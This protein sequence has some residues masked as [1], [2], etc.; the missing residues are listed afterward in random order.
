MHRRVWV[1]LCWS[2]AASGVAGCGTSNSPDALGDVPDSA[3]DA[4]QVGPPLAPGIAPAWLSQTGYF[5]LGAERRPYTPAFPLWSDGAGKSRSVYLPAPIDNTDPD[6]WSF[7]VGAKFWKEFGLDGKLIETRYIERFG[8][9]PDDFL[10][11][12]YLWPAS[13][14]GSPSDA[15]LV[16]ADQE[17]DDAN[18]TDHDVPTVQQCHQCHDKTAEHILGFG[19]IEL[20]QG[21]AGFA[22]SALAQA[23]LLTSP[24]PAALCA[25]PGDTVTAAA[26]GYLHTNCGTCHND[27]PGVY[28]PDPVM[29]L[30]LRVGD[31]TPADTGAYRTAVNVPDSV[32]VG[33]VGDGIV[34]RIEGGKPDQSSI[35]Y[36]MAQRAPA[37][38][39]P[40]ARRVADQMPPLASEYADADGMAAVRAFIQTLPSVQDQ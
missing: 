3:V 9:G 10:Y 18:G 1:V 26:L 5:D 11:A 4:T 14:A 28:L 12:T 20:G 8:S 39:T 7:P 35:L 6:H 23:G 25:P 17:I 13:D 22:Q 37:D 15:R 34:Y 2:I 40:A 16:D 24:P 36:R 29:D 21:A 31:K 27:A 33:H 30:R 19:A 32:F 38:G